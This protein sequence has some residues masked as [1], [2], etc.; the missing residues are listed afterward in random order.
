MQGNPSHLRICSD[1]FESKCIRKKY[2]RPLLVRG[3]IPTLGKPSSPSTSSRSD[4]AN[5][6]GI[7]NRLEFQRSAL[8]GIWI[9]IMLLIQ[10]VFHLLLL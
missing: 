7:D 4:L 5:D 10:C 6:E 8:Q 2:P 3:A 1:H 9:K